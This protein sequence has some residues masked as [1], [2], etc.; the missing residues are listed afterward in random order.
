MDKFVLKAPYQPTGDQPQAIEA[1]VKGFK[2]GNQ[3]QTL[4]GCYRFREDFHHGQRNPAALNKPT[5]IIAHN[6]TLAAQLVRRIQGDFS[7][8][9]Q[10]SIL[11]PTTIITSR[12]P[13]FPPRTPTLPRTPAINDEIDKLRHSATAA[14]VGAEGCDYR[15]QRVLYLRSGRA[16][17]TIEKMIISLRPGMEK[18]RDEVLRKL[19]DIQYDRND[20]DFKRGTFR[21]R[22]DV[23]EIYS[24][25]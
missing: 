17:W 13:M 9:T 12:R 21:V 11:F 5:L 23:L 22:G 10:W 8:I 18:D 20:M 7:R 16:R 15:G 6:K 3:C 14:L 1:L 25:Q 24:G 4:T 2:E 19:I